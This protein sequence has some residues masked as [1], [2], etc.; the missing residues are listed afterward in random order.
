[1]QWKATPVRAAIGV[2]LLTR[3]GGI[4]FIRAPAVS[5]CRNSCIIPNV[6]HHY[7]RRISSLAQVKKP[8]LRSAI[9]KSASR[10]FA[11]YGYVN[12]TLAEL[13]RDT[14]IS[15]ANLYSYVRS[16]LDILYAIHDGWLRKR[17]ASLEQEVSALDS[18]RDKLGHL[19]RSLWRDLPRE[20]NGFLNN[21]MEALSSVTPSDGYQPALLRWLEA[22]IDRMLWDALPASRRDLLRDARLGHFVV[23]AFDGYIIYRHTH[24]HAQFNDATVDAMCSMLLGEPKRAARAKRL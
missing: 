12:T 22:S 2:V 17:I 16:K 9:L 23:M 18:R 13:A 6:I 7:N 20:K 11:R 4:G 19:L 3:K 14:G 24:P 1:L 8:K 15:T 21:M 10:R 5:N